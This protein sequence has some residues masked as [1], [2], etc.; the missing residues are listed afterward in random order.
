MS[1]LTGPIC[2]YQVHRGSFLLL[3]T[4]MVDGCQAP[5]VSPTLVSH[6]TLHHVIF[7]IDAQIIHSFCPTLIWMPSWSKPANHKIAKGYLS[8]AIV[9]EPLE[10]WELAVLTLSVRVTRPGFTLLDYLHSHASLMLIQLA[11]NGSS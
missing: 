2:G 9:P 4:K 5:R 7:V 11:F 6:V 10:T 8:H 1:K 3:K